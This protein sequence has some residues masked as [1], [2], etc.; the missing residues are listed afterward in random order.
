MI[1]TFHINRSNIL[2]DLLR[3]EG[4]RP[5]KADEIADFSM[6]FP[7]DDDERQAEL[8]LFDR[9][10]VN[11]LDDKLAL[12]KALK[13]CGSENLMPKTFVTLPDYLRFLKKTGSSVSCYLKFS[14]GTASEGVYYFNTLKKLLEFLDDHKTDP[15]SALI[16]QDVTNAMLLDGVKFKLRVYVLVLRGWQVS[17]YRDALLV[18]NTKVLRP[19]SDDAEMHISSDSGSQ[20]GLLSELAIGDKLMLDIR[21]SVAQTMNRFEPVYVS[22]QTEGDY[23]LFLRPWS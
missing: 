22:Q 14:H 11:Q 1:R 4:W 3:E 12:Y 21:R 5:A 19:G 17:I 18:R 9:K 16:Q 6:W 13:G 10:L 8:S 20:T 7:F 15:G 2:S 23:H